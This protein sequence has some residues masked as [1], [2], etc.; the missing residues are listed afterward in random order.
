MITDRM[1]P[2]QSQVVSN[3]PF[4]PAVVAWVSSTFGDYL[5]SELDDLIT[6]VDDIKFR[7]SG[8]AGGA[9]YLNE[10]LDIGVP[11]APID[12]GATGYTPINM[13]LGEYWT[14]C[15]FNRFSSIPGED[16][17]QA[18]G[19]RSLMTSPWLMG[20]FTAAM[21][22]NVNI[23]FNSQFVAGD[24][25]DGT[26]CSNANAQILDR[27][28]AVFTPWLSQFSCK[29]FGA[30][31]SD[32]GDPCHVSL[33]QA[34]FE[35]YFSWDNNVQDWTD[36]VIQLAVI[37][38][39]RTEAMYFNQAWGGSGAGESVMEKKVGE[40]WIYTAKLFNKIVLIIRQ[41]A[42]ALVYTS[43]IFLPV[44][45]AVSGLKYLFTFEK[46]NM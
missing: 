18:K 8:M 40:G 10:V 28:R 22:N 25:P 2:S 9:R 29:V 34:M 43:A 24:P 12:Y 13:V 37:N 27:W 38:A 31:T 14:R 15:I 42:E 3:V 7:N 21:Y 1:S 35:R 19:I 26:A 41:L 46:K 45:I 44:L 30:V 6:D 17:D 32:P 5:G 16:S 20:A 33:V 39:I 4:L 11:G 23:V 36:N